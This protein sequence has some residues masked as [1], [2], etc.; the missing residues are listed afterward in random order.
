MFSR[1]RTARHRVQMA[2]TPRLSGLATNS[3]G[4]LAGCLYTSMAETWSASSS[5]SRSS[6]RAASPPAR[7]ASRRVVPGF[8]IQRNRPERESDPAERKADRALRELAPLEVPV[9]AGTRDAR[10]FSILELT[11]LDV[12]Q[13]PPA[14]SV[15]TPVSVRLPLRAS[16]ARAIPRRRRRRHRRRLPPAPLRLLPIPIRHQAP[17]ARRPSPSRRCRG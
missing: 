10:G 3:G 6:D 17:P 1:S 4:T 13:G 16:A 11:D 15:T 12:G 7:A 14:G 5:A 8:N 9:G 2:M